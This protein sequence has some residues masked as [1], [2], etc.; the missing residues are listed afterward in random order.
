MPKVSVIIPVYGVEKHIE[1]CAR[2][3]FEQTLDDIE[4]IFVDDCTPDKSIEILKSIID[5]YRPRL[6]EENKTVRVERTLTNSGLHAVRKYGFQ[7][8]T[9]EFIIHC[10]SDDWVDVEMYRKMYDYALD[11]GSD[12]VFC[13]YTKTYG[14]KSSDCVFRKNITNRSKD[15]ILERL[16]TSFDL[17]PVWSA[18]AKRELY[19]NMMFPTGAMSED[20]TIMIQL[21]WK[22]NNVSYLPEPLYYYFQAENSITHT[23]SREANIQKFKQVTANRLILLNFFEK[24]NINIPQKQ[25]V[26]FFFLMKIGFMESFLKDKECR[27][28][29]KQTFPLKIRQIIFNPYINIRLRLHYFRTLFSHFI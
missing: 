17:N 27:R 19:E 9:G 5:E 12:L 25:L 20:K 10:D 28:L 2:S 18:M 3:L 13:D 24:E 8:A 23:V 29:W 4:Y 22:A 6:T 15:A 1:K 26:A 7:F 21:V 11:N 16:L 14:N